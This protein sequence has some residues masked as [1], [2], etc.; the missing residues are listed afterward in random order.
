MKVMRTEAS[1]VLHFA[2]EEV[3]GVRFEGK[4]MQVAACAM[5]IRGIIDPK[6]T[7]ATCKRC[8]AFA[9]KQEA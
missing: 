5:G 3:S 2:V 7:E 1:K 9:E 4:P 8:L 6:A